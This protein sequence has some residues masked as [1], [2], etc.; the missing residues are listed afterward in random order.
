MT[1]KPCVECGEPSA[2][3]RCPDHSLPDR[4][5]QAQRRGYDSRWRRLSKKARALQ[6]FCSDC[7]TTTDLQAD[8]SPEAWEYQERGIPIPLRLVDVVCGDCNR[9]R[10]QA[11]PGEDHPSR[12]LRHPSGKAQ[13]ELVPVSTT[14]GVR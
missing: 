1:F 11:R 4:K 3:S 2:R 9:R 6:P 14:W 12:P 8:H 7:G 5:E 10:G 13:S